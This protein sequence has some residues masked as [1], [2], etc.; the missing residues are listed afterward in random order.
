[1]WAT[2][3][4]LL[5]YWLGKVSLLS[6]HIDLVLVAIVAISL[7]PMLVEALRGRSRARD[8]RYDEESERLEVLR[9]ADEEG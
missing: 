8:A 6:D 9:R 1:M 2:G 4:T 5:G 3:V 7:V